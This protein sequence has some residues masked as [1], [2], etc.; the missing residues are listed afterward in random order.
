L[1]S[2][3]TAVGTAAV[4]VVAVAG[5]GS[6][7]GDR[8]GGRGTGEPPL[9]ACTEIG[10]DS[11][12]FADLSSLRNSNPAVER[13]EACLGSSCRSFD[14]NEFS[15]AN[16]VNRR[17]KAEGLRRVTLVGYDDSGTVLL[18]SGVTAPSV[19]SQPNG[20]DCPPVCFQ[21]QVRVNPEGRLVR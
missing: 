13:A 15:S 4:A 14:R 18:R 16:I 2:W 21:V 11:G 6:S 7:G 5:C 1:I 10:C 8:D 20:E 9:H 3:R 17:L 12:L 19:R